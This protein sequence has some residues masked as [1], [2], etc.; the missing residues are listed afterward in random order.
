LEDI[1]QDIHHVENPRG[2]IV[3]YEF[4]AGYLISSM[5]IGSNSAWMRDISQGKKYYLEYYGSHLSPDDRVVEV[6]GLTHEKPR[7]QWIP[8]SDAD[9][10]H[11]F[12]KETHTPILRAENYTVL[13]P[14]N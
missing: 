9:P 7:M 8:Y 1:T 11:H 2:R 14:K 10:F 13:A 12:L 6:H 3:F 4:P 5:K